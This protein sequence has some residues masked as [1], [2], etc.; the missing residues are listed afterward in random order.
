MYT[1]QHVDLTIICCMVPCFGTV[2]LVKLPASHGAITCNIYYLFS[3]SVAWASTYQWIFV[4]DF[5]TESKVQTYGFFCTGT[6]QERTASGALSQLGTMPTDTWATFASMWLT[7]RA[8]QPSLYS[9]KCGTPNGSTS[10]LTWTGQHDDAAAG[11]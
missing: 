8:R 4:L 1:E 2:S 10:P 7:N 6:L 5:T 3:M 9:P 11:A